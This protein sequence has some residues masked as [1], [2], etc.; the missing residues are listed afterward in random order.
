M[1]EINALYEATY[2]K[3]FARAET[4]D[5]QKAIQQR[6]RAMLGIYYGCG[7]RKSEGI[8]LTVNDIL[9]ERKLIFIRKGK[10][11]KERYVPVTG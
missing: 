11:C 6:D 10:G 1:Q 9:T 8:G 4:E 2:Q 5:Y 3:S 7:L